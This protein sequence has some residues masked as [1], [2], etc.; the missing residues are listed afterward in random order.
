MVEND[1]VPPA[2][3]D[4]V[5]RADAALSDLGV[6]MVLEGEQL[7]PPEPARRAAPGQGSGRAARA[8]GGGAMIGRLAAAALPLMACTDTLT[9][10]CPPLAHPPILTVAAAGDPCAARAGETPKQLEL[11]I[12][13]RYKR[14]QPPNPAGP[15]Y[16]LRCGTKS[17]GYIHLLDEI[18]QGHHD[19]CDPVNDRGVERHSF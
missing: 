7:Q 8:A 11:R 12:V 18:A 17:Y 10:K 13:Q 19:H 5:N 4:E 15:T 3:A 16:P 9:A 1:N 14:T 2:L 6:P